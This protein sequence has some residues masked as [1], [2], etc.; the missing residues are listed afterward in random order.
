M[1]K[2]GVCVCGGGAQGF[3][4]VAG[5][6]KSLYQLKT[7]ISS[8]AQTNHQYEYSLFVFHVLFFIQYVIKHFILLF[9]FLQVCN[10]S[11]VPPS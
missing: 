7:R 8:R 10:V 1:T 2:G 9:M 4:T 11:I 3:K 5:Q 6:E